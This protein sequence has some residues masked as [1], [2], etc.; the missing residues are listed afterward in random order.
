MPMRRTRAGRG[1]E[2]GLSPDII[3][4][5]MWPCQHTQPKRVRTQTH[6]KKTPWNS[7]PIPEKQDRFS[8]KGS[9]LRKAVQLSR[10]G[11]R[12]GC[13]GPFRRLGYKEQVMRPPQSGQQEKSDRWRCLGVPVL[14]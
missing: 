3:S 4:R 8:R 10:H 2:P 7:T 14:G 6:D 11:P 5:F 9:A 12:W 1:R 13:L